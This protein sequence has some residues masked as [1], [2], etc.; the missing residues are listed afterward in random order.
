ML[1]TLDRSVSTE[2]LLGLEKP[3]KTLGL[4]PHGG[5]RCKGKK[6]RLRRRCLISNE[7]R[8]QPLEMSCYAIEQV[9][10]L[11]DNV[12]SEFVSGSMPVTTQTKVESHLAG[13]RDCRALVAALAGTGDDLRCRARARASASAPDRVTGRQA[14]AALSI[15]DRVGRYLVRRRSARAA[16]AWC[17]RRTIRELDRTHRA[18]ALAHEPRRAR[19]RAR[20]R[21]LR[22]A[23]GDRAAQH[24]NVVA[25]YDV[26]DLRAIGDLRRDGVRRRRTLTTWLD[27]A[28]R[29]PGARSSMSS[30]RRAR[31]LSLRTPPGSCIATSSPTT[32]SSA[33]TA[34]CA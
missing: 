31:G 14:A 16:W 12:A 13:C 22:E 7:I 25:V 4:L 2:R 11:D 21:L 32:C 17:S 3:K 23:R 20:A 19:A 10:C 6:P 8:G 28:S 33:A 27:A 30:R 1:R 29:A 24:P 26:G 15:G 18:Q 5:A 9:E 34:A